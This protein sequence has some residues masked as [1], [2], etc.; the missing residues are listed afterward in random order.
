MAIQ[1]LKSVP[2]ETLV[3]RFICTPSGYTDQ[4]FGWPALIE[5]TTAGRLTALRLPRGIWDAKAQE[6]QVRPTVERPAVREPEPDVLEG[7]GH[8]QREIYN[9]SSVKYVCDTAAEA[10]SLYVRALAARRAIEAFRKTQLTE[11]NEQAVAGTL[12]MPAY[13]EQTGTPAAD[14]ER[15]L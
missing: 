1:K 9:H 5:K 6:W 8:E 4:E 15:A 12:P 10:I 3:G 7:G 13:L 11:L 2:R 14:A